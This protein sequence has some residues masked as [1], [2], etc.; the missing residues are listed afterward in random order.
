MNFPFYNLGYC[1]LYKWV[2]AQMNHADFT[3]L[4]FTALYIYVYIIK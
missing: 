4:Y 2:Y 1:D 3:G